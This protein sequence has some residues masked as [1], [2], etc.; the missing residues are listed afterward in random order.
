MC[1]EFTI[2]I[3]PVK[4]C[5]VLGA[6]CAVILIGFSVFYTPSEAPLEIVV[7]SEAEL[8]KSMHESSIENGFVNIN[9]A[10]VEQLEVLDGIGTVLAQRIVNYRTEHGDFESIE[11]LKNVSG[12]GN[13]IFAKIKNQICV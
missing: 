7:T 12:I 2:R 11:E 3:S 5:I 1:T 4:V 6:I 9:T 13:T 8:E 10:S